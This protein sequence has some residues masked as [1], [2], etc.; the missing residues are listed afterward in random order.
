MLKLIGLCESGE[1]F[2]PSG[3]HE[4]FWL[5]DVEEVPR[6]CIESPNFIIGRITKAR[7]GASSASSIYRISNGLINILVLTYLIPQTAAPILS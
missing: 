2:A 7:W 5:V 1:K 4:K 6:K 3:P